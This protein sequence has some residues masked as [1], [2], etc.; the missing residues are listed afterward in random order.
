MSMLMKFV[1][2]FLLSSLFVSSLSLSLSLSLNTFL[3][4]Q[5]EL[6]IQEMIMKS[7]I[8]GV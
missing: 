4:F 6:E 7:I 1:K 2:L 5:F 8:C 3:F